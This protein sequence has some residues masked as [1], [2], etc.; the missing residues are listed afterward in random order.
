MFE[1]PLKI[2]VCLHTQLFRQLLSG[3]AKPMDLSFRTPQGV[4]RTWCGIQD[5][6]DSGFQLSREWQAAEHT[7]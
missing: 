7:M 6:G 2:A 3:W 1:N 4:H 5:A